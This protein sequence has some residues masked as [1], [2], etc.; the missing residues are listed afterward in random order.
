MTVSG[1]IRILFDLSSLDFRYR[2]LDLNQKKESQSLNS[3]YFAGFVPLVSVAAG[4]L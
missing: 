2:R 3:F 1:S 4:V